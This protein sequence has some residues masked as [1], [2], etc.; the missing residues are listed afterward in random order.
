MKQTHKLTIDQ[1]NEAVN[2]FLDGKNFDQIATI[3]RV[4]PTAIRLML[5]KRGYFAKYNGKLPPDKQVEICEKFKTGNYYFTELAKEYGVAPSS[6]RPLLNKYGLF[7]PS[8][9]EIH[10]KHDLNEFFF[11]E[12]ETPQKAYILG[13]FYAD[14]CNAIENNKVLIT[15]QNGDQKILEK[16]RDMIQPTK[17]LYFRGPHKLKGKNG[18]EFNSKGHYTLAIVSQKICKDLERYGMTP[19]KSMKLTWPHWLDESLIPH[20]V[21]GFFDGDGGVS[22]NGGISF[23]A[24]KEFLDELLVVLNSRS[25]C[26]LNKIH[27]NCISDAFTFCFSAR[28]DVSSFYSWLYKDNGG[29]FIDR[30]KEKMEKFVL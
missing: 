12:I 8:A 10:R 2:L 15:L 5:N 30:K 14:G 28:K 24:N 4:T 3:F 22:A 16:I 21:R 1:K 7:S 23:T 18:T 25:L 19:R 6:I 13:L 29:M 27:K 9:N 11:R 20:F 26:P 17:P